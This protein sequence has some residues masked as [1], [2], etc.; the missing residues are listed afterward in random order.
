[1]MSSI[2]L[3]IGG[4]VLLVAGGEFL[5]RGASKL[6]IS[7]GISALVVGL[8]V[9]AFGT[10]S[11]ELVVSLKAG[12]SGNADIAV[13]NVVGS[14]I[15]NILLI[16]GTC[17]LAL[18]LLVTQNLIRFDVPV[19]IAS[20]GIFWFFARDA[21]LEMYE[22]ALLFMMIIAYTA[23]SVIQSK[24]TSRSEMTKE[25]PKLELKELLLNLILIA[26]GLGLLIVG[27]S[28]LVDGA[29]IL[30]QG[31][32]VSETVIGLTIVAAGT[33]LPEL[34]TSVL[35]TI[36]GE[37]DIAIGNVVGSNIYNIFA[38]LGLSSM[39]TPGGLQIGPQMQ[40][41]DI[42][43]MVGVSVVSLLIF[44]TGRKISR[45][46]GFVMLAGYIAYTTYLVVQA[47]GAV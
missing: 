29:V 26:I 18:P 11:P 42:P 41:F 36:K 38:I 16:L 46:E 28:W 8:T 33:S 43:L 5:I 44:Y 35:A 30:A 47:S 24:R 12:L 23:Y 2:L 13:A 7:M 14:N 37:R 39:V 1:M 10:S 6:A 25:R 40:N 3:I 17:A 4:L 32:G 15:F 20:S 45:I 31:F 21:R 34:V 27:G 22:G 9:V 19:M